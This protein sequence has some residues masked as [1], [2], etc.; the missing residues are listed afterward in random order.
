LLAVLN[1]HLQWHFL[2]PQKNVSPT[3]S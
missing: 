2:F 3:S 1:F